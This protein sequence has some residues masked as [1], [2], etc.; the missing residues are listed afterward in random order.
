MKNY[1]LEDT[2]CAVATPA[3]IGGIAVLRVSGSKALEYVRK[4]CPGLKKSIQSHNVYFSTLKTVSANEALDEVL[5]TYFEKG[6]SFTGDE[7]VEISCHGSPILTQEILKNL[8]LAGC[9]MAQRGEFT[10]RAF[11][12]QRIDLTQAEGVLALIESRSKL[13]SQVS[14]R[15]LKGALSKQLSNMEQDLTFVLANLE[16]SIDFS[17]E[18]IEVMDYEACQSRLEHV[19]AE[20]D[21]ILATYE[22]GKLLQDGFQ[23]AIVG[24]PN[25]GKSSLLNALIYEDKAIVSEKAGTTRDIVEGDLIVNGYRVHLVDTA[26]IHASEDEIE[27]MGMERSIRAIENAD[28]I[29]YLVSP[30]DVELDEGI[31]SQIKSKDYEVWQSKSDIRQSSLLTENHFSSFDESVQKI[32]QSIERRLAEQFQEDAAVV[33]QARHFELFT[34]LREKVAKSLDMIKNDASQEFV[35]LELQEALQAVYEIFGKRFDDEVMDRVFR[36]FC[37]GK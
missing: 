34:S 29:L 27:R 17:T 11:M 5:I 14:L 23:V 13:A 6:K 33:F 19:A 22:H 25:A 16:A 30:E 18:D 24:K 32:R 8:I 21:R 31:Y 20:V 26:G 36:E 4:L 15:Q 2:I 9:R 7:V 12:N 28:F 37:I 3:G 35:V 10:Y 1:A